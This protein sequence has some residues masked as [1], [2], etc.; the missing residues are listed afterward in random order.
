MDDPC[1][2]P[3]PPERKP[4]ALSCKICGESLRARTVVRCAKCKTLHHL[5]CWRFNK[6]C[7]MYGCGCRSW[8]ET[9]AGLVVP[10]ADEFDRQSGVTPARGMATGAIPLMI[11]SSV[12]TVVVGA[13]VSIAWAAVPFAVTL[14]LLGAAVRY[15]L[16]RERLRID[17]EHG[18]LQRDLS[19]FGVTLK[20]QPE[21]LRAADVVELQTHA[22]EGRGWIDLSL[23]ALLTS[24]ERRLVRR[25]TS[26]STERKRQE[27]DQ[28]VERLA[29]FADCT[30]RKMEGALPPTP[31]EIGEAIAQ[32]RLAQEAQRPASPVPPAAATEPEKA[33][34]EPR[35]ER[36]G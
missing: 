20:R 34:P 6:G 5:D 4:D 29:V 21:W 36:A 24:G 31:A 10:A 1:A 17:A 18:A 7:S 14:G 27:I 12:L 2:K 26:P 30:V 11:F 22:P 28:L 13:S 15:G 33:P 16:C 32:K 25:E 3:V 9:P 19:L 8:E 23:Y 35:T